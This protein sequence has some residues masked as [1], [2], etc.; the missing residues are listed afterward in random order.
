[1]RH[2]KA[3]VDGAT[4]PLTTKTHSWATLCRCTT[5]PRRTGRWTRP[6]CT[7]MCHLQLQPSHDSVHLST[8]LLP[9]ETRLFRE[10]LSA[11]D[12]HLLFRAAAACRIAP[13]STAGHNSICQQ[14]AEALVRP[15]F[16]D[17]KIMMGL[18][19]FAGGRIRRAGKDSRLRF[20][21]FVVDFWKL[22]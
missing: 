4:P 2:Q 1:M 13:S 3:R 20:T 9:R 16:S 11:L 17:S 8:F 12:R 15:E 21:V 5:N 14:T 10:M 22:N 7:P 18:W 19:A 6:Q